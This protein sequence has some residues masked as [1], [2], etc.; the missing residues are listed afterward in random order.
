MSDIIKQENKLSVRNN[1]LITYNDI[2]SHTFWMETPAR[3][4][5]S[6]KYY[7][8]NQTALEKSDE[9]KHRLFVTDIYTKLTN[10]HLFT[11]ENTLSSLK[12]VKSAEN[13]KDL[14]IL[15]NYSYNNN[16]IMVFNNVG[17]KLRMKE[18]PLKAKDRY[19][20]ML[21]HFRDPEQY[22][23]QI[24]FLDRIGE[25]FKIS[26]DDG[27]IETCGISNLKSFTVDT[28][29]SRIICCNTDD[30]LITTIDL[31]TQKKKTYENIS[32]SRYSA[33]P[34]PADAPEKLFIVTCNLI[35]TIA[36]DKKLPIY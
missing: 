14:L 8:V 32:G 13:R 5:L 2:M 1:H 23:N 21:D 3:T 28:R 26:L 7:F 35:A 20:N 9:N 4:V 24:Y 12:M 34:V 30:R 6:N 16:T 27:L 33:S 18:L 17:G 19:I 22:K 15:Y 29:Y 10:E 36:W 11:M 25:L 31:E